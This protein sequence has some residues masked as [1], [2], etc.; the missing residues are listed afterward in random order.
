MPPVVAV[1]AL[2]GGNAARDDG[3]V[4]GAGE[5]DGAG[6]Q[7]VAADEAR[8]GL[9]QAEARFGVHARD[10]F[11]QG[12]R[13]H[14]AVGVQHDH[15]GVTPAPTAHEVFDVAGFTSAVLR[16]AAVPDGKRRFFAQDV[17]GGGFAQPGIRLL[18]VGDDE[19]LGA[20][21]EHGVAEFL[22]HRQQCGMGQR[23]IFA[24]NGH[25]QGDFAALRVKPALVTALR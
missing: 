12:V 10:H 2:P 19:D 3:A 7:G 23:R 6:E 21:G 15:V 16:A 18:R 14:Q 5:L 13:F 1:F 22:C 17:Q 11:D 8:H 24:I 9:Q 20:V 4:E 25:K